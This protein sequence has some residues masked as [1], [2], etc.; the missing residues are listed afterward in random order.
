[1]DIITHRTNTDNHVALHMQPNNE[2]APMGSLDE[3]RLPPPVT[4]R[5]EHSS[6]A[7]TWYRTIVLASTICFG[8]WKMVATV[9]NAT[10]V[11]TAL[12]YLTGVVLAAFLYVLGECKD[13]STLRWLFHRNVISDVR[14]LPVHGVRAVAVA[15]RRASSLS[16]G[17]CV[18]RI[19]ILYPQRE[20][21]ET[22]LDGAGTSGGSTTLT[23]VRDDARDKIMPLTSQSRIHSQS[24]QLKS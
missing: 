19:F 8:T 1:M 15:A 24:Y 17:S 10:A 18:A 5:R 3:T 4:S 11:S 16:F 20:G 2:E 21:R 22:A 9:Q 13:I 6:P 23:L 14:C 12:D 7:A